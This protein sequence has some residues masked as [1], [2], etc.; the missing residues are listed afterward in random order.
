MNYFEEVKKTLISKG[1]KATIT[2]DTE[3][4][5]LGLDSLDLMDMVVYLEEK[6]DITLSDDQLLEIKTVNDLVGII[7]TLAKN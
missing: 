5:A 1:T 6:L 4:K 3:F 7:E 2:K